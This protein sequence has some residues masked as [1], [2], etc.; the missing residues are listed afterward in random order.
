MAIH[1]FQVFKAV[2]LSLVSLRSC[3]SGVAMLGSTAVAFF[4]WFRAVA[5]WCGDNELVGALT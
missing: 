3:M 1:E 4:H 5:L 2:R